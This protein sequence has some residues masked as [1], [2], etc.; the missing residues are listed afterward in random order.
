MRTR[1][2]RRM[3]REKKINKNKKILENGDFQGGTLYEKHRKKIEEKGYGYMA[4]HG[5]LLHFARGTKRAS[6]KVRDRKAWSGTENWSHKDLK[7]MNSLNDNEKD[8]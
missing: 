8:F 2:E 4:K 7:K 6:Q 3:L 5:T 1:D